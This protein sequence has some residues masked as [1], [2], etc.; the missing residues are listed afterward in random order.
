MSDS[1]TSFALVADAIKDFNIDF[2]G[3][4]DQVDINDIAPLSAK[5]DLLTRTTTT[6]EALSVGT[7]G[8]VLA[9]DSTEPTGVKWISTGGFGGG[10]WTDDGAIV[11][12]TTINDNVGIGT[13]TPGNQKLAVHGTSFAATGDGSELIEF[14]DNRT[15]TTSAVNYVLSINRQN[16]STAAWYFGNDGNADAILA[17]NNR[18][19]RIGK[20]VSGTFTE[21][22]RVLTNGNVGIGV[23]DPDAKLEI[24]GQIKITGGGPVQGKVLTSDADGLANWTLPSGG[25][26]K[27]RYH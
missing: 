27:T 8:F 2:G 13:A 18:N 23:T 12:L 5:G 19:L 7:D 4:V 9:A 10:G 17:T 3:G 14:R 22:L 20:D 15:T 1:K 25:G 11:R 6:H 16:S 21:H 26:Q 24:N